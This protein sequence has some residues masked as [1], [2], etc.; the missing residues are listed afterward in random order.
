[1]SLSI[2]GNDLIFDGQVTISNFS[3]P[4]SVATLTL[5]PSGGV[6]NLPALVDGDPGLPPNLTM[7][8]VTTLSAGASAT[9]SFTQTATGGPGVASAYTMNL[10]IPRGAT[11][12]AG[13]NSTLAGCS[14]I[15]VSPAA[16]VGNFLTVASLSPTKYNYTTFPWGFVVNP[17][18][19]TPLTGIAG[20]ST[21]QMCSLS[22][23]AQSSKWIPL[24]LAT[25]TVAGTVNTVVNL[26]ATLTAGTRTNDVIGQAFGYA[27]Q[28][29]QT[30]SMNSGFGALLGSGYGVVAAGTTATIYLKAQETASTADTWN[31]SNTTAAFTVI[32]ITV[33]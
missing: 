18:T 13:T 30:L 14:D 2:S 17:S 6:G 29:T 19:I 25:A 33:A 21:Q 26:I 27:G 31:V 11:G 16:A 20:Q 3:N 10:G 5:T 4:A 23:A 1:M 12:T 22:I 8:T 28:A 15:N 24:C 9:G 32:G 7:G